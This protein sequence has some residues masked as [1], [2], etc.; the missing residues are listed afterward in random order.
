MSIIDANVYLLAFVFG[1]QWLGARRQI[2]I[3][4]WAVRWK[5]TASDVNCTCACD[6]VQLDMCSCVELVSA[7]VP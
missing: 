7:C 4:L 6:G 2:M 5:R 1:G 3:R